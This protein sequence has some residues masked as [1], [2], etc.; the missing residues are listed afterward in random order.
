MYFIPYKKGGGTVVDWD[1]TN[2]IHCL[3]WHNDGK[4][5]AKTNVMKKGVLMHRLLTGFPKEVDHKNGK[6]ND[7]RI[8]NLRSISRHGNQSNQ[9]HHRD[10]KLVRA[11]FNKET[12]LWV[13]QIK[14][15]ITKHIGYF[16][17]EI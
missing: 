5:Y 6:P 1:F 13:A 14:A 7:N 11:S 8:K 16:K 15:P 4:G 10:G 2:P 12:K 9:Y 3:N 17:S